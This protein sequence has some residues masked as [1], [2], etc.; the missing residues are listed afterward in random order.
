M[1]GT[2][3]LL[4]I[5][6]IGILIMVGVVN[7][8]G[9]TRTASVAVTLNILQSATIQ[10]GSSVGLEDKGPSSSDSGFNNYEGTD[11][12]SINCNDPDGFYLYAQ[13]LAAYASPHP[14]HM[15]NPTNGYGLYTP[16]QI[17][18]PFTS[19]PSYSPMNNYGRLDSDFYPYADGSIP[20]I[21]ISY[22]DGL[23]GFR[24]LVSQNAAVDYPE[25]YGI[26]VGIEVS[27]TLGD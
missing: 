14:G 22:S 6:A 10:A 16:L 25:F 4:A 5:L 19:S 12:I 21:P 11:S 20:P 1:T 8:N 24:Q 26:A 2:K 23:I 13:D 3:T 7:G 9:D 27:P 15:I 18:F 17:A